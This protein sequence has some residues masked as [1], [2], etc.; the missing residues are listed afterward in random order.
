MANLTAKEAALLRMAMLD[1]T[2]NLREGENNANPDV[3]PEYPR[4]MY[5]K[6]NEEDRVIQTD[7]HAKC[8][9]TY[10]VQN[11]F[12]G[13]LCETMIAEDADHAEDLTAEGWD[14]TPE[15][16]HGI[17][18]GLKDATSA[19]DA[20]IAEL[21]AQLAERDQQKPTLGIRTSKQTKE[22]LPSA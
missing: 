12:N 16:A 3:R 14:V 15:A 1:E 20:R 21:E 7:A 8:G 4:M 5:R 10:L 19:K 17:E 2:R 22:E 9:E 18:S 11:R 13:L 6:T